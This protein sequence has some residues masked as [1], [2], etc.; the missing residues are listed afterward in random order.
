MTSGTED[1]RLTEAWLGCELGRAISHEEH[2][3]ISFVLLRRHGRVGG[4]RRIAE[5]TLQ[6][7]E[8]LDAAGRYDDELTQRWTAALADALEESDAQDAQE[9]L[10][11]HPHFRQSDL[12]G[13]PA[14]KLEQ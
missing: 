4:S 7:C 6:N 9:F 12:Y 8:E 11:R 14:W 2:L 10:L 5:G 13:P 3:R 1:E